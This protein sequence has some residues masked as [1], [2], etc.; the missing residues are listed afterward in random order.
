MK[1]RKRSSRAKPPRK[2][3]LEAFMEGFKKAYETNIGPK[4]SKRAQRLQ[5]NTSTPVR[6]GRG[7]FNLNVKEVNG[8]NGSRPNMITYWNDANELVNRLRLLT[9]SAA[10]GHTGHNN[11]ILAIIEELREANIIV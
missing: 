3:E 5:S 7:L 10:A 6:T 1:V 4:P 11:E 2:N 9:A 8:L